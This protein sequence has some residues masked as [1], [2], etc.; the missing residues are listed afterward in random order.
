[1]YPYGI[2]AVA[3]LDGLTTQHKGGTSSRTVVVPVSDD[4][5]IGPPT[6]GSS[7]LPALDRHARTVAHAG[8]QLLLLSARENSLPFQQ[9]PSSQ[10]YLIPGARFAV[11]PDP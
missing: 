4:G 7:P 11:E 9:H 10:A 1:V 6:S 5:S 3:G 2:P 8:R